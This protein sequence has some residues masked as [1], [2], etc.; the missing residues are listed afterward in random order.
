MFFPAKVT[1][2]T[3]NRFGKSV[4]DAEKGPNIVACLAVDVPNARFDGNNVLTDDARETFIFPTQNERYTRDREEE[5]DEKDAKGHQRRDG[6]QRIVF[7]LD[8][9]HA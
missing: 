3:K 1:N 2:I 4:Q 9:W 6:E 5:R 8:S 7:F